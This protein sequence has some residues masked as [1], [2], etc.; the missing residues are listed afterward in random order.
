[1]TM[2]NALHPKSNVDHLYILRKEGSRR[3]QGV[4]EMVNLTNLGLENYVKE[5]R[6]FLL[7]TARSVDIDL[8]E[9]IQETTIEA[10][11]QKREERT[12]FWEDGHGMANLC[13]KLRKWAVK[14]DGSCCEIGL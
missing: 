8:L 6:E 10:K 1:M 4:E 5:S 2:H 9:P 12:I 11:K 7:T 13:A 3:L 14:I